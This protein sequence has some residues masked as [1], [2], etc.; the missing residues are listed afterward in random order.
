MGLI[1]ALLSVSIILIKEENKIFLTVYIR[2]F[3]RDRVFL[4]YIRKPFLIYDCATRSHLN[5]RKFVL[6]IYN[7][8]CTP[9]DLSRLQ[10]NGRYLTRHVSFAASKI[11]FHVHVNFLPTNRIFPSVWRYT[12]ENETALRSASGK[13]THKFLHAGK[14]YVD[15]VVTPH[16]PTISTA[17]LWVDAVSVYSPPFTG[18]LMIT[19]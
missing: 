19:A 4:I 8:H 3:R 2:K 10:M 1:R 12:E 7:V 18:L 14:N 17:D 13:R 16:A 9:Y 11:S 5:F 15:S 6:Y